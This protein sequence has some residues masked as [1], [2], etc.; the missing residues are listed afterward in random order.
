MQ[1]EAAVESNVVTGN[2]NQ[3]VAEPVSDAPVVNP[4]T[5]PLKKFGAHYWLQV[6]GGYGQSVDEEVQAVSEEA[7]EQDIRVRQRGYLVS[8]LV[9]VEL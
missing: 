7:A 2:D 9:L 8:E 3:P 5:A 6:P 4:V 1:D